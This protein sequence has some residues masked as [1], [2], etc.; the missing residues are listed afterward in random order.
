MPRKSSIRYN[1]NLSVKENAEINKVSEASV[2]YYIKSRGIDRRY[3]NK[4][5]TIE[6]IRR[7]LRNKPSATVSDIVR[8]TGYDKNTIRKYIDIAS[9]ACPGDFM[10]AQ[11]KGTKK[12][13][14][15]YHDFYATHPSCAS[16]ILREEQFCRNV[17]EPFCGAGSISEVVKAHG[18]NVESY[19]IVDRGY[20]MV[21]DFFR[22][23]FPSDKYDIISNPP[24]SSDLAAIVSRCIR[25]CKD[26]VALIMPL[27]Y[28]SGKE[29]HKNIYEI[30]PPARIYVYT[31]R[32]CIAKNA[33][34]LRYNDAGANKEIYAWYVWE[35]GHDGHTELRWI[36]NAKIAD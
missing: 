3:E 17:L 6:G 32:I 26:K 13:I 12:Q 20:G 29:R 9:G 8:D 27:R 30:H 7:C 10:K 31:E 19:D 21:G 35:K 16:D 1:A 23:D 15:E 18:Y 33:D 14:R 24:Y 4:A 28:L 36:H 11:G 34:F 22:A 2:R 5:I 25:L